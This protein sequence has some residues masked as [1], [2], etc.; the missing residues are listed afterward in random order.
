MLYYGCKEVLC[1]PWG[2]VRENHV[3]QAL[4][5]DFDHTNS[6]RP[7]FADGAAVAAATVVS[8]EAPV[9][10]RGLVAHWIQGGGTVE[11]GHLVGQQLSNGVEHKAAHG[12]CAAALPRWMML[13]IC[14]TSSRSM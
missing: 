10:A 13:A 7:L 9:D 14:F 8:A 11:V 1:S 6:G 3:L 2:G 12:T 5:H 4:L